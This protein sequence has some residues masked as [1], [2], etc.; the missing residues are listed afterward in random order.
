M[1][2]SHRCKVI[3]LVLFCLVTFFANRAALPTDIME[4]RNIITAREIV[5]DGNWLVPTMNGELRLEKPPLPTWV[6]AGVE[7]LCPDSLSA[8]RAAAGVMGCLWTVY[9]FL[10]VRYV[11][12][13]D[14]LATATV[15]VFLTCYNVVL[16]GRSATWDIY[17]H[18]FMMGG[19]YYLTLA[20]CEPGPCWR[21]FLVSG[22]FMGLSFLSKGPVS[23]Y[24][25]LLPWLLALS[26][27][28]RPSVRGKWVPMMLLVVVAVVV[29]GWWYAYLLAA[30]PAEVAAVVGKE[31]GAWA[32]HNVRPWYYYWRF[33]LE[34]GVWAPLMLAALAIPYWKRRITLRDDYLLAI[35]WALGSLVLLSLMPEKK[36]RYLL[37]SLAPCAMAVACLLAHF[38]QASLSDRFSRILYAVSGWLVTAVVVALPV[39]MYFFVVRRGLAG[40]GA[41]AGLSAAAVLIGAWLA[42]S[43]LRPSPPRF[44]AG[45]CALFAV[46][47]MF[48]LGPV[49][50]S[51]GNPGGHSIAAVRADARLARIPFYHNAEEPLRIE[52]VYEAHRKILP[53]DLADRRAVRAALPCAIVSQRPLRQ[54]MPPDVLQGLDTLY[55][56]SFDD[57]KHPKSD[58]HY[59]TDFINRVT[60]IKTSKTSIPQP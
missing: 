55:I 42:W 35:T 56:G 12:R 60:L 9:L 7:E 37:P 31:T 33:F 32:N 36:T 25:L 28:R 34:M 38:R 44:A 58:R 20:L 30:H 6:A 19:I 53:L 5:A 21:R 15:M 27:L 50:R 3:V 26:V 22:L 8:Q 29:G 59:T 39:L 18:A 57:N 11:S 14:D 41:V 47:E 17:C 52:L 45:V 40:V 24:T 46:V 23:F 54:E 51:F 48:F 43:T 2:I 1:R 4:A 13:R 49:G 16:M 10:L